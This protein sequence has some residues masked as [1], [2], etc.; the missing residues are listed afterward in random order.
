MKEKKIAKK[1]YWV[2]WYCNE[3]NSGHIENTRIGEKYKF[4][5]STNTRKVQNVICDIHLPIELH[6]AL[7][8]AVSNTRKR[9]GFHCD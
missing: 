9:E 8:G 1:H 3:T 6:R 7:I 2:I 4:T 5:C